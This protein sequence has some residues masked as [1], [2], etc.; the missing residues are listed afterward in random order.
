M[1]IILRLQLNQ[2]NDIFIL[3]KTQF[4][5]ILYSFHKFIYHCF[6]TVAVVEK[7]SFKLNLIMYALCFLCYDF[8]H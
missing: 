8:I 6:N 1:L 7:T 5:I 4:V 3:I 2:I